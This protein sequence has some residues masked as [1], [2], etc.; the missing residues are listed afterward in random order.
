MDLDR[1]VELLN[2]Y[3]SEQEI[4]F[5]VEFRREAEKIV[6]D[7]TVKKSML[8]P[9]GLLHGGVTSSIG[10][11]VASIMANVL[12]APDSYAVGQSLNVNHVRSAREGDEV[13]IQIEPVHTGRASHVWRVDFTKGGKT[14][15]SLTMT[16]A[17]LD[18]NK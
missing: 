5:G 10:E 16:M 6:A 18:A 1:K 12:V 7:F 9:F 11:G 4:L 3:R 13:S 15:S 17:I 8:Q 2:K 14:M